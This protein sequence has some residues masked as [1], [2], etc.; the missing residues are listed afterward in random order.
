MPFSRYLAPTHINERTNTHTHTNRHDESQYLLAKVMRHEH[1]YWPEAD[2]KYTQQAARFHICSN[3]IYRPNT[4]QV[5]G[6]EWAIQ[7]SELT[8]YTQTASRHTSY[9]HHVHEPV[10][11]RSTGRP[12]LINGE[13][14][15][16]KGGHAPSTKSTI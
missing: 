1:V 13:S 14:K 6:T 2:N 4:Q 9:W 8:A 15:E 16:F 10:I 11:R 12:R 5:E 7:P 3:S